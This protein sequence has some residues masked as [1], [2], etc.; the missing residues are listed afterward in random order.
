MTKRT[1]LAVIKEKAYSGVPFQISKRFKKGRARKAAW[2]DLCQKLSTR[3]L[4]AVAQRSASDC[5]K[6]VAAI[7]MLRLEEALKAEMRSVRP[8]S[9]G[10]ITL[11]AR[12]RR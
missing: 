1:E 6:V 9:K 11:T 8:S 10:V 7:F 5:S 4:P 2:D 12:S 3:L